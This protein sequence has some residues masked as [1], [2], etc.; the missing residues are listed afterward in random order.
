MPPTN[1]KDPVA[2]TEELEALAQTAAERAGGSGRQRVATHLQLALSSIKR[3]RLALELP[4]GSEA[5]DDELVEGIFESVDGL[6]DLA[7]MAEAL[8]ED[9]DDYVGAFVKRHAPE[10]EQAVYAKRDARERKVAERA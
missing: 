9:L 1:T 4:A 7:A 5:T 2:D 10:S 3:S 6:C 8:I